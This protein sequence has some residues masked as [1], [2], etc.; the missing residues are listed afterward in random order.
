MKIRELL[1]HLIILAVTAGCTTSF[2]S[3][4]DTSTDAPDTVDATDTATDT[5]ADPT[6]DED[7]DTVAP[8]VDE[9]IVDV[10]D[11]E[12]IGVCGDGTPEGTE[13]CD[14]GNEV[15]GDGC[16]GDCTWSCHDDGECSDDEPCNGIE[17]CDLDS[18]TCLEGEPRADGDLV[19]A[20]PPRIICLDGASAESTCG[21][22][23]VDTGAGEFCEPP[24]EG[25]CDGECHWG[26]T[27]DDDC[28]DDGDVC[29][30]EE[31]CDTAEHVCS[32]RDPAEEGTVCGSDP[33][34]ICRGG[35]CQDSLC[36]DGYWDADV[37]ECDDGA[38]GDD[39]DGCTNACAYACH[40]DSDCDDGQVCNGAETCGD[41]PEGQACHEG[42]DA[43]S[44]TPCDDGDFCT[45][46]DT[47]NGAGVCVG[48]GNPCD[49]ALACTD[50]LCDPSGTCDHDILSGWC[51]IDGACVSGGETNSANICEECRPASSNTSWWPSASTVPCEGDG[52]P[53]TEDHCD[54][55]GTCVHDIMD[56]WCLI[57]DACY[58][59]E[60]HSP[61]NDCLWC[62]AWGSPTSWVPRPD[63]Q[64]CPS[65]GDFCDGEE[66][67]QDGFCTS[68]GDP[69]LSTEICR[70]DIGACCADHD[71]RACDSDT[72]NIY[73]YDSCGYQQDLYQ[74]CYHNPPTWNGICVDD[75]TSVFC[76]CDNHW[77]GTYCNTCPGNWDP[78]A[79]C[80]ACIGNYD[81][82]T[83][84]VE[85]LPGW[86][87]SDCSTCRVYADAAMT[88]GDGR[89]WETAASSL[90][91]AVDLAEADGCPDVW[92]REGTYAA[93]HYTGSHLDL[94]G[95]VALYGGFAGGDTD[96]SRR[97]PVA[98]P[99]IITGNTASTNV[100]QCR[101]ASGCNNAT[102]LDGFIV[103]DG[104]TGSGAGAGLYC[105][106]A[107]MTIAKCVFQDNHSRNGGAIYFTGGC[108]AKVIDTIFR[109]NVSDNNGGAVT[110]YNSDPDL[111]NCLF[112]DN[113]AD[114]RGGALYV[115]SYSMPHLNN[116][117]VVYNASNTGTGAGGAFGAGLMVFTLGSANIVNTIFWGNQCYESG[118]WAT[119]NV[120][121]LGET[122]QMSYSLI[123][124]QDCVDHSGLCGVG[125][126]TGSPSFVSSTTDDFHLQSNSAAIDE[127][128]DMYGTPEDLD[129]VTRYDV[130]GDGDSGTVTD[131]GC[132]E[133][134]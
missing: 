134:I 85:C 39:S 31:Y 77:T 79:N 71:H 33:R 131:I 119:C 65:N 9:D 68:P 74:N 62:D 101:L 122:I 91:E 103:Q 12:V 41:A 45:A 5:A 7:L 83:D 40:A 14:D 26:C 133:Y 63:G 67:C 17:A 59:D 53:C 89:S 44:D 42:T 105:E 78:D 35:T 27:S 10:V 104:Y 47:C 118:T 1:P 64:S 32:R 120:D 92:V 57:D 60:E 112:H 37:E 109:F 50:D 107:D 2:K 128:S 126:V 123:E 19:D 36:G 100:V 96:M 97:D 84:C 48:E 20:G 25:A 13:E 18:H 22:D 93:D 99:T 86:Y 81:P 70:G 24:G 43:G 94:P 117:T 108:D 76:D 124:N 121:N 15:D 3:E 82:L 98:H 29:N 38:D 75:G 8:D 61:A 88:G 34:R 102:T 111:D 90:Q 72:Q 129:G 80:D 69:C 110:F 49:D 114:N 130:V 16:D 28:T 116:C 58:L 125:V 6:G 51:F 46:T 132:Y 127:G 95:D 52:A 56:D 115:D 113:E 66:V 106:A 11:E 73:W 54:G 23:F 87:G 4:D 30:G 55:D 21:D